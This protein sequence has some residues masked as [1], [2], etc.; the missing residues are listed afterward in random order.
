M[1]SAVF[2]PA[3]AM[4]AQQCRQALA[5]LP[6]I[7]VG[8]AHDSLHALI[9]GMRHMPPPAADYLSVLELARKPLAFLQEEM[10]ATYAAKPLPLSAEEDAALERVVALWRLMAGSY[11]QVAQLGGSEPEI[12]NHLALVCQRC[13]HYAGLAVIEHYR[14]RRSPAPGLWMDLHGYYDT[15]EDWGIAAEPV[16]EP[17]AA[18]ART[19]SCGATYATVLLVDLANPYSRSARELA[20]IQRWAE[21]LAA[22]TSVVRPDEEAGGRG[23]GLDL[24][25]D[26]GPRPVELLSAKPSA[27]LFDTSRL[28]ERVKHLLARLKEGAS[29][30]SLGLGEDST[31]AAASRLLVQLYRPWCLAA[32][33]RRFERHRAEGSVTVAYGFDAV[34]YYVTEQEFVQPA[35]SRTFS[36]ADMDALWTFRSQV[37]PTKPL[38]MR[39]AQLGYTLDQ[40]QIEDQ[41]LNGFRASR[42]PA[43]PRAEHGQLLALKPPGLDYF[44]LG[45]ISWLMLD[46]D[47][48]LKTGIQ[49]LPGRPQGIAVRPTGVG[50]SP[51]E[52]YERA[53]VLPAVPS[54]KE[55]ASLLLPRG[56]FQPGRVVEIYSSRG[57]H[58]QLVK[59]LRAGANFDRCTFTQA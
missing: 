3:G 5:A 31:A 51:S 43:G 46:N 33:P 4:D 18:V 36:R 48:R 2:Q 49:L 13:L 30:A 19:S 23:F 28:E 29:P 9:A 54:L 50:V 37:D 12:E 25:Q 26:H 57:V 40:W 52:K 39:A 44:V 38:V 27:R 1:A 21:Q 14:A 59:L 56:W 35:H 22:H 47:G 15:A 34:H 8:F 7:N 20:W 58:V 32:M 41:S 17:M 42:D 24:M 45:E 6:L 11:A 53:F 16:S 10:A 55:A